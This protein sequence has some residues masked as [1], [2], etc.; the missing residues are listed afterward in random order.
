[1][2]AAKIIFLAICM[3]KDPASLRQKVASDYDTIASEWDQTR[4]HAW[5][6]FEFLDKLFKKDNSKI[7]DAGCGNGRLVKYLNQKL[8]QKNYEYLG[9]DSSAE[10]LKKAQHNFP[11]KKFKQTDL[12]EFQSKAEY[13]VVACIAV[14]HHLP[15]RADRLQVLKNIYTSLQDGGQLFLT[16]WNL[17]QPRYLKFTL[18]SY[19]KGRPRECQIPF[20]N[21]VDRYVHAFTASELLK[22]CEQAGF[23]SIEVFSA[24]G[25]Q[26]AGIFTGRNLILRARK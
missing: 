9:I 19:L 22:L 20:A 24:A 25:E 23:G 26:K 18:K 7:L 1:M 17:W 12:V 15:S 4:Q 2:S 5:G 13:D 14:L 8:G 6:E 21:K 3:T 10:L 11:D 16:V